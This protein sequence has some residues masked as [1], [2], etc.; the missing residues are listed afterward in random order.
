MSRRRISMKLSARADG[1][2]GKVID[3]EYLYFGRDGNRDLALQE[4][5]DF[6]R[7]R[8]RDVGVKPVAPGAATVASV[9]E[10]FL[11]EQRDRVARGELTQ[12]SLDDYN[13]AVEQFVNVVGTAVLI[14][15][16]VPGD[17]TKAREAWR[18]T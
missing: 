17:F 14:E 16:L 10:A 7:L 18:R 9:A 12:G 8:N 2:F 3:G 4:L 6:I 15:D 1:R 11:L 5:A 13:T